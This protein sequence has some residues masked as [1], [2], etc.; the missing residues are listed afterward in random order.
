[1]DY[2]GALPSYADRIEECAAR[3]RRP[4]ALPALA[5]DDRRFLLRAYERLS[6]CL[7]ELSLGRA[8][9]HGDAHLGNVFI[10][11]AGPLWT[12]FE[13]ACLG[14]RE[15]DV[16]AAPH[17]AAFPPLDSKLYAVLV[18]IRCICVVVWCSILAGDPD[19]HAAAQDQ[20]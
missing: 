14:P 16:A 1:A 19:K 15:W 10:T 17:P 4:V 12:D 5:E 18:D 3:L 6:R 7:A 11:P 13:A 8:P 20:L 9:I 2:E